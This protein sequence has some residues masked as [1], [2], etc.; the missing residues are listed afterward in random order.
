V[1]ITEQMR[2]VQ[3]GLVN[4]IKQGVLPAMVFVNANF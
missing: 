3:V 1:N 4:V 2:G